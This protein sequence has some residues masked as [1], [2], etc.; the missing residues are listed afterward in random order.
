MHMHTNFH[1]HKPKEKNSRPRECLF[2]RLL[3]HRL[4]CAR[5]INISCPIFNIILSPNRISFEMLL[6]VNSLLTMAWRKSLFSS[7]KKKRLHMVC[8][9][10][11]MNS[12]YLMENQRYFTLI[13]RAGRGEGGRGSWTHAYLVLQRWRKE[14]T[15]LLWVPWLLPSLHLSYNGKWQVYVNDP[16]KDFALVKQSSYSGLSN[17][18][19]PCGSV[20]GA[21]MTILEKYI[22]I[23][24]PLS[25]WNSLRPGLC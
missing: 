9:H 25:P 11:S 3:C 16:H 10:S 2:S 4:L 21:K 23:D 17:Y 19:M 22:V 13:Q 8:C 1:V 14:H 7:L 15:S 6:K 24:S 12:S 18:F 20:I 5:L